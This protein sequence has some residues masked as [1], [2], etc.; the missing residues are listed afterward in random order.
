M[1]D[2]KN[3]FNQPVRNYLI[4][5]DSIRKYEIGQVDDYT[6]YCLLD[7]NYF[8][9]CYKMATVRVNNK[10]LMLIQKQNSKLILLEV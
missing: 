1:F 6:A 5:Y 9:K 4:T 7:Y 3:F 2:G 10:H 8:K